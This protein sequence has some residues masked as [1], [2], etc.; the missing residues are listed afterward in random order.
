MFT[1]LVNMDKNIQHIEALNWVVIFGCGNDVSPTC[2][3]L[4]SDPRE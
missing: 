1:S 4:L 3:N 2:I